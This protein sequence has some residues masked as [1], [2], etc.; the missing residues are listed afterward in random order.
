MVFF[1]WFPVFSSWFLAKKKNPLGKLDL[2]L[3]QE[4]LKNQ[5]WSYDT[6][7]YDGNVLILGLITVAI[8]GQHVI[9]P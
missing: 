4:M 8:Q 1:C 7:I 6:S 5:I 3:L 2:Q 9:S